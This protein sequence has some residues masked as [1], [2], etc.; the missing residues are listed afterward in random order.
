LFSLIFLEISN[1]S[2]LEK[3]GRKKEDKIEEPDITN[4]LVAESKQELNE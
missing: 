3:S 4:F 1:I 2:L